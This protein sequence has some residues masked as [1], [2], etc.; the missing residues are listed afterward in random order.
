MTR[1][2]K[3]WSNATRLSLISCLCWPNSKKFQVECKGFSP[4]LTF[5]NSIQ[6]ILCRFLYMFTYHNRLH[7]HL[8]PPRLPSTPAPMRQLLLILVAHYL[9]F[10]KFAHQKHKGGFVDDSKSIQDLFS[11]DPFAS[12]KQD[13]QIWEITKFYPLPL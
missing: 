1:Y 2:G 13:L 7:L 11:H 10:K 12:S 5:K 8:L 3:V 6:F 9:S 4:F